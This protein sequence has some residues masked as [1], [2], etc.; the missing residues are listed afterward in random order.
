MNRIKETIFLSYLII[1][2]FIISGCSAPVSDISSV[3]NFDNG[4][5]ELSDNLIE[6]EQQVT[7]DE[8][9]SA[10]NG[11]S[12]VFLKHNVENCEVDLIFDMNCIVKLYDVFF[13]SSFNGDENIEYYVGYV[14]RNG[15]N[16]FEI[17]HNKMSN[18]YIIAA[19]IGGEKIFFDEKWF[20]GEY[21]LNES[22][23]IDLGQINSLTPAE[24]NVEVAEISKTTDFYAELCSYVTSNCINY[25][26]WW[27]NPTLSFTNPTHYFLGNITAENYS[28]KMEKAKQLVDNVYKAGYWEIRYQ[29]YGA[30]KI[31]LYITHEDELYFCYKY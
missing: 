3:P 24:F 25:T 11:Y 23:T 29:G 31:G 13:D 20:S 22:K 12:L 28:E 15:K 7:V 6:I 30:I 14:D 19:G 26:E 2:I 21:I 5:V 16:Q 9:Y 1:V 17:L 27:N 10:E 4:N 8:Y 18:K